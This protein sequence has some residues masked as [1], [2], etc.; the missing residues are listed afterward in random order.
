MKLRHKLILLAL[1]PLGLAMLAIAMTVRQQATTLSQQQYQAL[2]QTYLASKEAELSHYVQ[3]AR[4]AIEPLYAERKN[5]PDAQSRALAMLARMDFGQDG[6]F[7]VYDMQGQSLMHPRQPDLIGRNL[8]NLRDPTGAPTIQQLSEKA[9]NGGGAVRYLW[10]KPSLNRHVAKLG[11]VVPLTDWN[12][13][14]G[15]GI[16]LDDV[17]AAL[18]RHDQQAKR[19]IED[20]L[21]LIALITLV[22]LLAVVGC[23]LVLNISEHKTSDAKLRR[24]AQQVVLSQE[25]ERARISRELHDGISQWLVSVKLL[26]ESSIARLG[27]STGPVPETLARAHGRLNGALGEI[28]RISHGLRPTMLDDLGLPAA[29]SE[30]AREAG[31]MTGID[32]LMQVSGN[33][34]DLN[35]MA[36]T[37]LFRIAQE[38]LTNIERHAAA[39]QIQLE[40]G[41]TR[42]GVQLRVTDDGVG[43]D[44]AQVHQDPHRGLGLRNMRERLDSVGGQLE[45]TSMHG[46]TRIS[47]WIPMQH[48]IA[49]DDDR[50]ELLASIHARSAEPA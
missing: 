38:A 39:Q 6:Y 28:R 8:W 18:Q 2:E 3:L 46:D 33:P 5:I 32:V 12:W 25:T 17:D 27:T 44:P 36:K 19:H 1:V 45:I 37:V 48:A 9:F 10:E 31:E 47:A 42:S 26:L 22:C 35:D 43:F 34:V 23:G 50:D 21:I 16:Y 29:L 13:M 24:L 14:L 11:Y 20:T 40:L 15:S 41:F 4:T 30:L 7:F 49:T